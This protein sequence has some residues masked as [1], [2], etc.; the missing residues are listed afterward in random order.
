MLNLK[1]GFGR[2]RVFEDLL[3]PS[4]PSRL[5]LT[6]EFSGVQPIS[7]VRQYKRTALWGVHTSSNSSA[8]TRTSSPETLVHFQRIWGQ[9]TAK[10][11]TALHIKTAAARKMKA[12][13][14]VPFTQERPK[15][16]T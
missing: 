9:R 1:N 8:N 7:R 5:R 3:R 10:I 11:K 4:V 15:L 16:E 2:S 14:R 12:L 13:A 6:T